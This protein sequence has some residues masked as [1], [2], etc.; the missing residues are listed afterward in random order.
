MRTPRSILLATW[1][2]GCTAIVAKI[3]QFAWLSFN[4]LGPSSIL[5]CVPFYF[6]WLAMIMTPEMIANMFSKGR[7]LLEL[8]FI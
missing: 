8:L 7:D 3:A 1:I 4:N 5:I 2:V 6:L